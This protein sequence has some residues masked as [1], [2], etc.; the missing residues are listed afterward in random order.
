[1]INPQKHKC[2]VVHLTSVHPPFDIRI[3]HKECYGLARNGFNV[4]LVAPHT[5][6]ES[7]KNVH[8]VPIQKS[9]NRFLR[10]IFATQQVLRKAY[11]VNGQIYHFHDPE[12][13]PAGMLL[14]L[15]GSK[16]IYDVHEDV[17]AQILDKIWIPSGFRGLIASMIRLLEWVTSRFF[18]DGV[19]AATSTIAKRFPPKKTILVQN[20]PILNLDTSKDPE[21]PYSQRSNILIYIG[22]ITELRGIN[23]ICKSLDLLPRYLNTQLYL[24]GNF[25][26]E[27][28]LVKMQEMPGWPYVEF[29]GWKSREHITKLLGLSR[30][31]L[32]L[33]HPVKNHLHSV[34]NK[35][36]EYML[37]G[38]PVIASHFQLW[39]SI[40]EKHKCG[41]LVDPLNP[42]EIAQAIEWILTHP[43]ESEAM[44]KRGKEAVEKHY[45]W[46]T[47]EK[48]LITLYEK[49]LA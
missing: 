5:H 13:I 22:G 35:I 12:L 42:Q 28:L 16:V 21:L 27:N 1:M 41:I 44:G 11:S 3:F 10:M 34:P 8:V 38:I 23:E 36:F 7:V 40:I 29:F 17:P 39:K 48:K 9:N 43:E 4:S 24:A 49:L 45:R 6:A 25:Y 31:G 18:F 19:V 26:P 2:N 30:V 46:E 20:F 15:I 37:A 14:K 32:L 47:E 33:F